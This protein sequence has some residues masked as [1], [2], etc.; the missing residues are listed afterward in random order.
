MHLFSATKATPSMALACIQR[1]TLRLSCK[2]ACSR[3]PLPAS[4]QQVS[5]SGETILVMK[6]FDTTPV[7]AKQV[8]LWTQRDP[9]MSQVLHFIL[10]GWPQQITSELKPF[11]N[12]CTELS[13]EDNCILWG[14]QVVIPPQGRQQLL[15]EIHLAHPGIE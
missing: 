6:H 8:K 5:T 14:N 11:H 12:R 2:D 10:N 4:P 9:V 7:S 15:D 13:V 1:W 3:L